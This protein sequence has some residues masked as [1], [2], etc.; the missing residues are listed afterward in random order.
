MNNNLQTTG[1]GA[2]RDPSGSLFLSEGRVLRGIHPDFK[3]YYTALLQSDTVQQMLG[4][5][6]VPTHI[7]S[8]QVDGYALVLE[9]QRIA[10]PSYCYEWPL[11]MLQDAALLTLDICTNLNASGHVLKDATPW[12]ILFDGANPLLVDFTSI[13][14]QERD[15]LWVAYDQFCRMF[16]FPLLVGERTSG[17][18]VRAMHLYASNGISYDEVG[19]F[20]PFSARLKHPWLVNRLDMPKMMVNMIR[21][22]EQEQ[23]LL[24]RRQAVSYTPQGR[25]K[26]FESLRHDLQSIQL[27]TGKSRWSAYYDDINAFF[28]PE[29]FQEK[30]RAIAELVSRCRPKTVVDI[31]CNQ[32]GYAVLAA[33]AGAKVAAFDTDEDSVTLL[34]QL[35]KMK[36]LDIL[37]LVGDITRPIPQAGWRAQ[38]FPSSAHRFRSEMAFALALVHHLAISQ[39]QSFDRI[40]LELADYTTRWLVTEFVPAEDPRSQE[41][42]VTNRREMGWYTLEGF[43]TALKKEFRTVETIPSYPHGRTL[44]FCEK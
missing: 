16:L 17:Q 2:D 26:F 27:E 22:S 42:L 21:S 30:Q 39:I 6:I 10:M 14:P 24:K 23:E 41:I 8:D 11:Q 9:H 20:L 43:I 44:C 31:G 5:Q 4:T 37:P 3:E 1:L 34:Y 7:A 18:I 29:N 33:Q 36:H 40:T 12:N 28:T 25:Q 35:A 19:S 13:M 38:E 15:L 32:G